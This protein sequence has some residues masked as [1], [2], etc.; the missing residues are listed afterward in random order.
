MLTNFCI[1][2]LH[3]LLE[4]FTL[5]GLFNDYWR[6]ACCFYNLESNGKYEGNLHQQ[7]V[8]S[9]IK[10]LSTSFVCQESCD[11]FK[12]EDALDKVLINYF[13]IDYSRMDI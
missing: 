8:I 9:N 3:F 2:E 5:L 6:V 13:M 11:F 10:L 1:T 4:R 12:K 7:V